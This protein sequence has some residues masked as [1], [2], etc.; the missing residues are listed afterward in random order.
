MAT[1]FSNNMAAHVWAQFSQES[2]R[3]NN[4][5]FYFEGRRA[6]SYGGHYCAGYLA[7]APGNPEGAGVAFINS[8]SYSISTSRHVSNVSSATSHRNRL[9]LPN[10]TPLAAA[11]ESAIR[12]ASP[13][14]N[15]GSYPTEYGPPNARQMAKILTPFLAAHFANPDNVPSD[16]RNVR[17]EFT[18]RDAREVVAEVFRAAQSDNP[19]R[20]ARVAVDKARKATKAAEE[21]RAKRKTQGELATLAHAA[22]QNPAD[23]TARIIERAREVAGKGWAV[24]SA[25]GDVELQSRELFR[26]IK[27]GKAAGHNARVRKAQAIRAAIRA[28]LPEFEAADIRANRARIFSGKVK[29]TRAAI[30]AATAGAWGPNARPGPG[31][32]AFILSTGAGAARSLAGYLAPVNEESRPWAAPSALVSGQ[33]PAELADKL[34]NLAAELDSVAKRA[35]ASERRARQRA[36]VQTVRAATTRPDGATDSEYMAALRN[37]EVILN[38]YA[39]RPAIYG[40]AG[41]PWYNMPGAWRVAGWTPT[42]F[43]EL[44]DVVGGHCEAIRAE[45]ARIAA[46]ETERAKAEAL[47]TWRAGET[48]P[49]ELAKYAP[50]SMAGGAAYIRARGV[51]RDDSGAI[52]GGTLETSQG[53]EVPLPHAIRVFR[54]LKSCRDAGKGWRANGRTLRVGHFAVD[55]VTAEGDF[56]AG[57]HR[58]TWAEVAALAERLGIAELAPADTTETHA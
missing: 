25:R 50:R 56:V 14:L 2:G 55:S 32:L 54:F 34:R 53:A 13:R 12:E 15:P 57:C 6:F 10:L 17:A 39:T 46:E 20:R 5:N 38:R 45:L 19:E 40:G 24:D 26:A 27:A 36:E 49:R 52:M 58:F 7:P 4:G 16:G 33:N 11:F 1:V 42:R 48:V 3:S 18:A 44:A 37:A 29:E 30:D 21:N 22:E 9:W 28:A 31:G 41:K 23:V 47:E 43:R 51:E 8:D 35:E